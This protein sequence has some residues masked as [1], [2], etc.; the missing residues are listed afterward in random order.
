MHR[1]QRVPAALQGHGHNP[2]RVQPAGHEPPVHRGPD[3]LHRGRDPA[4]RDGHVLLDLQHLHHPQPA[5]RQ[6]RPGHGSA[7]RGQPCR[8][9]GRGPL[10]QVLP[11]GLLRPLLPGIIITST[12]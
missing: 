4:E 11:V 5:G 9:P 7:G 8:G 6:G 2:G 12:M 1:Q 3:R 10:S